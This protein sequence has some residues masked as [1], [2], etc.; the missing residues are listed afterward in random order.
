MPS[1]I[2]LALVPLV[3]LVA[4]ACGGDDDDGVPSG[5]T[6]AVPTRTA[7][8]TSTPVR[9]PTAEATSTPALAPPSSTARP[10]P[11]SDQLAALGGEDSAV[12]ADLLGDLTPRCQQSEEEVAQLLE[13]AWR[14]LRDTYDVALPVTSIMARIIFELPRGT[15]QENC[16]TLITAVITEIIGG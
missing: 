8:A 3:L 13:R 12:I 6:T 16:E 15:S 7:E 1:H 9:T 4:A 10:T 11:L 5:V 14:A 2:Y